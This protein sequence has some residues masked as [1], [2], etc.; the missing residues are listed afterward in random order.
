MTEE[1]HTEIFLGTLR[2]GVAANEVALGDRDLNSGLT[3][4][5]ERAPRIGWFDANGVYLLPSQAIG[6]T[7]R[8][9]GIPGS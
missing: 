6:Y 9:Q 8:K 5:G 2:E 4:G 7:N 3:L 1:K